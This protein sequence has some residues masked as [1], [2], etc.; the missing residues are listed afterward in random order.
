MAKNSSNSISNYVKRKKRER[1]L[2]LLALI[3]IAVVWV[4]GAK[5]AAADLM[6]TIRQAIP[7]ADH[8]TKDNGVIYIAWADPE[9]KNILGY[10]ALGEASGYGGKLV[11]AVGVDQTGKIVGSAVASSKETPAWINRV[12]D[13]DLLKNI[14]G[15]KYTEAFNI[16]EDLDGVTGATY[17]SVAV[18]KAA[19]HG[20]RQVARYLGLPVENQP[21]PKIKFGFPEMILILLFT[22]GYIGHQRGFKYKKQMRWSSLIIGMVVL[23][24]IYNSPIT[25]AYI[26]KMLLG[27]FPPW[28]TNLYWYFLIGG[29]LFVFT[30][31][32]KNPYCDWFCPFGAAQECMGLIGGAKPRKPRLFH[33]WL[34]WLQ[35]ILALIAIL[36]GI[37]FRSPGLASYELFGTLFSLYG[38]SLQF[39]AL[40]LVLIASMFIKRP[41]CSFLCPVSPVVDF[42]RIMREWILELWKKTIIK[43]TVKTN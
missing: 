8:I 27:Y 43:K 34:K 18:A 14:N 23:G 19:L 7:D 32:N 36:L 33:Q 17:S 24:F 25:I 16:G 20:S 31:D 1:T 39:I 6:P 3:L 4:V 12:L 38:S 29:I 13:S 30:V 35:R 5:R 15:K 2:A 42:I 9:E 21:P 22:I 41:W 10:V 26:T 28:Q 40:G 37:Y 11:L